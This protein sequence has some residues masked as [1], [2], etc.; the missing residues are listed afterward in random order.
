MEV[1]NRCERARGT[2]VC[3]LWDVQRRVRRAK[4]MGVQGA[5][6]CARGVEV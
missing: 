3:K 1:C 2:E 5:W 4:D 6:K